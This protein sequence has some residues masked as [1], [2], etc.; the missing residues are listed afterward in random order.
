MRVPVDAWS[1]RQALQPQPQHSWGKDSQQGS[2]EARA[3]PHS[4][5]A[6]PP[7]VSPTPSPTSAFKSHL[8]EGRMQEAAVCPCAR[9]GPAR[10]RSAPTALMGLG[11]LSARTA[12]PSA[13]HHLPA[14]T[15]GSPSRV[16]Q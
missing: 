6:S 3:A 8:A 2:P 4:L 13:H 14:A 9:H 7:Q 15:T 16:H 1:P 11:G 10:L 12:L 5:L